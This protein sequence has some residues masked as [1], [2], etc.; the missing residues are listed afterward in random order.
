LPGKG[1]LVIIISSWFVMP[2]MGRTDPE[3]L[4]IKGYA[5]SKLIKTKEW[6]ATR[7]IRYLPGD[8]IF[9]KD[10]PIVVEEIKAD[11]KRTHL[12]T[13]I[14]I[15]PLIDFGS[16]NTVLFQIDV[17][18]NWF[19]FPGIIAELA[20]R[21]FNVWWYD[22][23][24][25]LDRINL[26]V[27]LEHI[28]LTGVQDNLDVKYQFGFTNRI[29]F[30]YHRP[31]WSEKTAFG[32]GAG[33][34]YTEFK[35]TAVTT[36]GN[37]Q[38]FVKDGNTPIY[39]KR[40]YSASIY[41]KYNKLVNFQ[42]HVVHNHH[43]L[44]HEQAMQYPEF[45]LEG[46]SRQIFTQFNF[47]GQYSTID[48]PLR[49]TRGMLYSASLQQIG[50]PELQE[51]TNTF[52]TQTVKT[53]NK[54]GK[55]V[56][57]EH[58]LS[59]KLGLTRHQV[60]YNLYKGLGYSASNMSGYELYVID[61]LDYAYINNQLRFHMAT[62]RW[63]FFKIFKNEPMLRLKTDIDLSAQ[64]NLA[65]V[66]DPFFGAQNK[67]VNTLLYSTGIGINFTVNELVEFNAF[68]SINHLK[69]TGLYFHTRRSF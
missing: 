4:I 22:H 13:R 3:K 62:V 17:H 48:H 35:E 21:N 14:E 37:K 46:A 47:N 66:N 67:L 25:S 31:A 19:I 8:S 1:F 59:A 51:H 38:V 39:I 29:G 12:F 27:T 60:P 11:L 16:E 10:L 15:K 2:L 50:I 55:R 23:N 28:N 44:H 18:E 58:A 41:Y 45:F 24:A 42:I 53:A 68:F 43:H 57:L 54:F 7:E 9:W 56:H 65:Y 40:E 36:V 20:D 33:F 49:P 64:A 32:F 26:G 61:G 5:F 63:D 34:N 6:Y 69:D 52:L 30:K